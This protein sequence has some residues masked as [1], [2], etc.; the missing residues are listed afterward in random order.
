M[1]IQLSIIG[2]FLEAGKTTFIQNLLKSQHCTNSKKTVLICC[3]QG[4]EEYRESILKR[5]NTIRINVNDIHMLDRSFISSIIEEHDPARI[6]IEYNGTWPIGEF[7]RIRL[8]SDCHIYNIFFIANA[9]NF[10]LYLNNMKSIMT[11]Q[12][13]NSDIVILNRDKSLDSVEKT[14]IKRA[15]KAVNSK[16][17]AVYFKNDYKILQNN[18]KDFSAFLLVAL[19]FVLYLVFI[20]VKN[21]GSAFITI[22]LSI[23]IQALPF[24]LIGIFIS[25]FLQVFVSD[26]KIVK[27]FSR[28]K[29]AGFPAAVVLGVFFPV[30]DCAMAPI[31]SRLAGKGVPLHYVLTFLLSAPVVNP[32]VIMSTYYAFPNKPEV[33]LMRVGLG[34]MIALSVGFIVKFAGVTKEYAVNETVL[35]TPCAGGY[36]GD[37][38]Q[39]GFI[40]KLGMLIRH[41]GMEFFN[42]GSYIVVGAFVTSLIQMFLSRELFSATGISRY[43]ELLVM[44]GAA[45]FMS[46]CSTSNAFIARGFSYSFPMYGVVCYMV[47]GPMLDLKNIMM[48]S[49]GF[50]KRFL[51][52]LILILIVI[53]VFIFSIAAA[54]FS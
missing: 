18:N 6:F 42:V 9:S 27:V 48:L 17:Q 35:E 52:E 5:Y 10:V 2:G 34:V 3:E 33:V 37:F 31:C 20:S 54:F 51:I 26:E 15:I 16:A 38:S 32:V 28:F 25:S 7:L 12:I 11:E 47:M 4:F 36:I 8:P 50:K 39:E 22:F 40:G 49:A 30:C 19:L 29:W 43:V 53:A 21:T 46:V 14:N 41:A 13:S 44:L 45:V 24:I 23:L 1:S